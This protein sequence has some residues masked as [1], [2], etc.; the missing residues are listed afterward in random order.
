MNNVNTLP[1]GIFSAADY[2]ELARQALPDPVWQYLAGGSGRE[3][4][5]RRNRAAFRG[6]AI[7][8][9]LLR[10]VGDGHSRCQLAGETLAHPFLLSPVAHQSLVHEEAELAAAQG[11][12]ATDT[13]MI[14]STLASR[15]LEDIR[16]HCAVSPWFQLY[17]QAQ[18]SDTADLIKRA[19]S[20]GFS[21]LVVTLDSAI[22][23]PGIAALRAGFDTRRETHAINISEYAPAEIEAHERHESRVFQGLM[24][25]APKLDDLHWLLEQTTLPIWVKGV[26]RADDASMLQE[27]GVTGLFVSNHGGRAL[28]GM[29]SSLSALP[30]IRQA[31]GDSLPL[32]L[33]GGIRHGTDAFIALAK[34]ADAVGVGRLQAC[35]LAV[36]GPLG[37]AHMLRLL[38]EELELTMAQS[39]CATLSDI[40]A[41]IFQPIEV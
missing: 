14:V 36:A 27:L 8:P 41:D 21:A 11:A 1:P 3:I 12:S 28:D 19:E 5:V 35:A 40:T 29:P 13:R 17:F 30:A 31:V 38:R 2:I 32:I 20:A 18:R 24:Q 6:D 34:G 4:T 7:L 23:T 26:L 39:G 10:D 15:R 33:D 25:K 16:P 9:R 37:V 22:Q